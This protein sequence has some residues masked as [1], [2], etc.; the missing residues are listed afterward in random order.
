MMPSPVMYAGEYSEQPEMPP[1]KKYDND[2][3]V[4]IWYYMKIGCK[5]AK[6]FK[7]DNH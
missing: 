3:Q 6:I 1:E 2:R 7:Y 4:K 5:L